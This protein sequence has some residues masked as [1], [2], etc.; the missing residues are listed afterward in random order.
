VF[1]M[2]LNYDRQTSGDNSHSPSEEGTVGNTGTA[3]EST[4]RAQRDQWIKDYMESPP[5]DLMCGGLDF[6]LIQAVSND[7]LDMDSIEERIAEHISRLD[8][9]DRFCE[10]CWNGF[11]DWPEPDS[12]RDKFWRYF[13][14]VELEA[15][16]RKGCRFCSL[17]LQNMKSYDMLH[18]V[19]C[20]EN[21]LQ[22]AF[23][24]TDEDM[25]PTRASLWVK[26]E[27]PSRGEI[28]LCLPGKKSGEAHWCCSCDWN[29]VDSEG[30]I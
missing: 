8:I 6:E 14:T 28:Q 9:I 24:A 7:I 11:Q 13:E 15:A 23:K 22:E 19:R 1:V 25:R 18:I 3:N 12:S 10:D 27:Y 20:I 30:Q 26:C 21:R 2:E 4:E 29:Y 17:V 16:A 5:L